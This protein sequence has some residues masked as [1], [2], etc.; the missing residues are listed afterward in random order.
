[1][2]ETTLAGKFSPPRIGDLVS[3]HPQHYGEPW[4][5]KVGLVLAEDVKPP[6]PF[7]S[8]G[9]PDRILLVRWAHTSNSEWVEA[10]GMIVIAPAQIKRLTESQK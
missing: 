1:M 8:L 4:V 10:S 9:I 2:K 7:E 3:Y 5:D 6:V